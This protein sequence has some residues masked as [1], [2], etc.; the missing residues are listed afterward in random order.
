MF[1]R[2]FKGPDEKIKVGTHRLEAL[3]DGLFAI[4]MTLMVLELRIPE[5]EG[6]V[7]NA[8]VWHYLAELAPSFF[9]FALSF[10]ILGIFWFAHRLVHLFIGNS[11][12]RLMWLSMLFYLSISLIPFSAAMLGRYPENQLV[13]VIYGVN[14]VASCQF[15]YWLWN[16]GS[17]V[18]GL[19]IGEV[20]V[21]LKRE[22][23]TLFL[24][25][26]SVYL[27][28]IGISFVEPLWSFY[29]YLI[30]P[31]VYLIPTRLDQYLPKR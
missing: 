17:A 29:F 18:P 30:T 8:R 31:L 25:A 15:L 5:W 1:T 24:F 20:P 22:I 14:M 7:T 16:Y 12:R 9:A 27:I 19:L 10:I 6:E 28:A 21:E 26:P 3:G 13:E 4:V 2:A 23:H 11:N